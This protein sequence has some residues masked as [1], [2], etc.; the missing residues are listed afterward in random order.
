MSH[1]NPEV[2]TPFLSNHLIPNESL[3]LGAHYSFRT[4]GPSRA[5]LMTGR[6]GYRVSQQNPA[7]WNGVVGVNMNFTIMAEMLKK[8]PELA[9]EYTNP[10]PYATHFVG[11]WVSCFVLRWDMFG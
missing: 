4:C 8:E 11:K 9:V 2:L 10:K 5:S 6:F 7:D 3:S 1:S